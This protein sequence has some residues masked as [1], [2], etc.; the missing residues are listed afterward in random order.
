MYNCILQCTY[1][2]T[3]TRTEQK[4]LQ[5]NSITGTQKVTVTFKLKTTYTIT[6]MMQETIQTS[7]ETPNK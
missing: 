6:Q 3:A 1:R 2:Q 7:I 5:Y 4:L